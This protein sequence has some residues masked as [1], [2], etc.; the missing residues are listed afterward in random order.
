MAKFKINDIVILSY[1][2]YYTDGRTGEVQ[3]KQQVMQF[4]KILDI[5]DGVYKV[6]WDSGIR[7]HLVGSL[8]LGNT[9]L[10]TDA[11]RVLYGK[12]D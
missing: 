12:K 11:E 5:N 2:K 4:G 8:D 7:Q 3:E 10:A 9:R 1:P 6:E